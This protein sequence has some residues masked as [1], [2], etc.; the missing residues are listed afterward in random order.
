MDAV[1]LRLP[2]RGRRAVDILVA[3]LGI[4]LCAFT[5][6]IG[7]ASLRQTYLYG[8]KLS[9]GEIPAWPRDLVIPLCFALMAIAYVSHLAKLLRR[10]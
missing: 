3:L 9:S 2:A 1:Y 10:R 4:A 5:A 7:W 8:E 6:K